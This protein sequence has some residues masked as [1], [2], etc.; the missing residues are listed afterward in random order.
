MSV[1]EI[2]FDI[3][4]IQCLLFKREIGLKP[5]LCQTFSHENMTRSSC[6]LN[7]C[8]L[9][10]FCDYDWGA[11]TLAESCLFSK[12]GVNQIQIHHVLTFTM[13]PT[14]RPLKYTD[15]PQA[16]GTK[17]FHQLFDSKKFKYFLLHYLS[18]ASCISYFHLRGQSFI[19]KIP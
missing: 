7:S 2:L 3:L 1:I 8:W 4:V 17:I 16:Q 10:R 18:R 5:R 19:M 14:K 9:E 11:T 15:L 6:F 13:A 12:T